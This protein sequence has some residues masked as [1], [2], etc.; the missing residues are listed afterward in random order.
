MVNSMA[1]FFRT[2][3]FSCRIPLT[4]IYFSCTHNTACALGEE[5]YRVDPPEDSGQVSISQE[6]GMFCD[7]S[8]RISI[9]QG[10]FFLGGF[11]SGYLLSFISE[12]IGR[13]YNWFQIDP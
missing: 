2:P 5:L 3:S 8:D 12:R 10:L 13:R 7:H 9:V 1:Y 6:F 11:F 4:E